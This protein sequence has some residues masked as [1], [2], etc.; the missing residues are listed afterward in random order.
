MLLDLDL[1]TIESFEEY[2]YYWGLLDVTL[3]DIIFHAFLELH[4]TLPEKSFASRIL[5]F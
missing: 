3:T 2:C 5:F 1:L 4:S